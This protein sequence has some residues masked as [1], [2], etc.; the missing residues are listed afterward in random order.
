[1]SPLK[2]LVAGL[3]GA[4]LIALIGCAPVAPPPSVATE[5]D[6][7]DHVNAGIYEA[8]D[9]SNPK[10][11]ISLFLSPG[12]G[13]ILRQVQ[14]GTTRVEYRG[15]WDSDPDSLRLRVFDVRRPY[16]AEPS[17]RTRRFDTLIAC[18]IYQG[19]AQP[20]PLLKLGSPQGGPRLVQLGKP[21]A[22]TGLWEGDLVLQPGKG[23]AKPAKKPGR[24]AATTA[25]TAKGRNSKDTPA[26]PAAAASAAK[27][28]ES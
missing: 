27:P 13:F 2:A 15:R 25:K 3:P 7:V 1:M 6:P 26:A 5:P 22:S 10:L 24:A 20:L 9:P 28:P 17:I 19:A 23:K 16:E 8:S 4:A 12:H 21:A 14:G 11:R 18:P